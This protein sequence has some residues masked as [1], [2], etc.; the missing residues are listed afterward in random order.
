MFLQVLFLWFIRCL[1]MDE[2]NA[3]SMGGLTTNLCHLTYLPHHGAVL[4]LLPTPTPIPI[5]WKEHWGYYDHLSLSIHL[6]VHN[7]IFFYTVALI[8]TKFAAC[9]SHL[10]GFCSIMLMSGPEQ[11]V[12]RLNVFFFFLYWPA[13]LHH[14]VQDLKR[15]CCLPSCMLKL[16]NI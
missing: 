14:C 13:L 3:L 15:S 1:G 4:L 5:F 10:L 16:Y 8:L 6:S 7:A 12:K 11:R 9:L 2:Y